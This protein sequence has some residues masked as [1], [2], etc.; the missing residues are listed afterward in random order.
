M[1]GQIQYYLLK[2]SEDK[3]TPEFIKWTFRNL[4]A[5]GILKSNKWYHYRKTTR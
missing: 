3:P 1:S 4:A 5:Q 2:T